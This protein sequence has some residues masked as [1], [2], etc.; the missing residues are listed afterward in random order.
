MKATDAKC[1]K[2][3]FS[4]F[5]EPFMTAQSRPVPER[6]AAWWHYPYV[7]L[8]LGLLAFAVAAS[9]GL[10]YASIRI[11]RVDALYNDP[12]F[13]QDGSPARVT[14]PALLPAEEARNHAATG[15]V[16]AR[17]LIKPAPAAASASGNKNE[18]RGPID[19]D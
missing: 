9:F 16:G 5:P 12:R 15:G 4:S 13:P 7:W 8:I 14:Q 17:S 3:P 1:A 11:S 10:L 2:K 19:D 18:S 6:S